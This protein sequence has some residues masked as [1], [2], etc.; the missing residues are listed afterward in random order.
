[1]LSTTGIARAGIR[2]V[3]GD[4]GI[5]NYG[6]ALVELLGV[7]S[8]LVLSEDKRHVERLPVPHFRILALGILNLD[9]DDREM[10]PDGDADERGRLNELYTHMSS[11]KA[12]NVGLGKYRTQLVRTVA[13]AGEWDDIFKRYRCETTGRMELPV[14]AHENQLDITSIDPKEKG[15]DD[16]YKALRAAVAGK[17][18]AQ[19]E[20]E[21][22]S[23][24]ASGSVR[25]GEAMV[26]LVPK[27][28]YG[29]EV[30]QALDLFASG[31]LKYPP[32]D[33]FNKARMYTLGNAFAAAVQARDCVEN[34]A[35]MRDR[36]VINAA[37]KHAIASDRSLSY[38][39]R[40]RR[41]VELVYAMLREQ[42]TNPLA[43]AEERANGTRWIAWFDATA[44]SGQ[45][46]DD[47]ADAVLLGLEV[48][49]SVYKKWI[50]K[51]AVPAGGT[52]P[53]CYAPITAADRASMGAIRARPAPRAQRPIQ[54]EV[55]A[56]DEEEDKEKPRGKKAK[57]A[58]PKKRAP[59]R[60]PLK[61]KREP[62]PEPESESED[63][64][65]EGSS[66]ESTISIAKKPPQKRGR[67]D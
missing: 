45:K 5:V 35:G 31:K 48:S 53:A 63:E 37:K 30:R 61:R 25:V 3:A 44:E 39:E 32:R 11:E 41:A 58:A 23:P 10:L 7:S 27:P 8:E 46:L 9:V 47:A 57:R 15:R 51:I 1:M 17:L 20:K 13:G 19:D 2:V 24:N 56:D 62:E 33:E 26:E 34:P 43:S 16:E 66:S 59:A 64:D 4:P 22:T 52:L 42:T 36:L 60:K 65:Y 29:P 12:V 38:P 6:A 50:K 54:A 18:K 49:M 67:Y 40:K 55:L 28:L 14:F 21:R